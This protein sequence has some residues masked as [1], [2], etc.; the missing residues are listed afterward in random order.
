MKDLNVMRKATEQIQVLSW[1]AI[2]W[3]CSACWVLRMGPSLSLHSV[4]TNAA[5]LNPTTLRWTANNVRLLDCNN[6]IGKPIVNWREEE[7][8]RELLLQR[9]H[10]IT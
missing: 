3:T 1:S 2:L 7:L 4:C 9:Q 10:T 5:L 8:D 6:V